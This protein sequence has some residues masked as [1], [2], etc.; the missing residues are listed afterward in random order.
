MAN[1]EKNYYHSF[2]DILKSIK[3]YKRRVED[4]LMNLAHA[5]CWVDENKPNWRNKLMEEV[6]LAP[7][8][9]HR[10][11]KF[12]K[13]DLLPKLLLDPDVPD[14][15]VNLT[16]EEQKALDNG[17][18]TYYNPD[19][20][21][22]EKIN[23]EDVKRNK[24]KILLTLVSNKKRLLNVGEQ[25]EEW[26]RKIE[27]KQARDRIYHKRP[28]YQIIDLNNGERQVWINKRTWFTYHE[29]KQIVEELKR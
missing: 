25:K 18:V 12:A 29:M 10:F 8:T 15:V 3:H 24:G 23:L 9:W 27:E 19:K 28:K 2:D 14:R 5:I 11:S 6:N 1:I 16:L 22:T 21:K 26:E 7:D 13:G 4:N 17:Q 20:N